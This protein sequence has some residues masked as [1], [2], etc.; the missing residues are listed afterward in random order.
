MTCMVGEAARF[1]SSNLFVGGVFTPPFFCV[2]TFPSLGRGT[3]GENDA[4]YP[5]LGGGAG[6]ESKQKSRKDLF[7]PLSNSLLRRENEAYYPSP[8]RGA[9]GEGSKLQ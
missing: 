8:G 2:F 4:Y 3:G 1:K 6:G 7:H 9:R 5:S